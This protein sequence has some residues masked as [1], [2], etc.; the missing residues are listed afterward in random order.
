MNVLHVE[1]C[2]VHCISHLALRVDT[3]LSDDGG[4]DTRLAS[5]VGRDAILSESACEA[6]WPL[7]VER[8]FL[9]VLKSLGSLLL[10][11]LLAVEEV[12]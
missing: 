9:V 7:I 8:L 5:A 1:A 2:K 10:A 3:L 12:A 11:T 6:L 4:L